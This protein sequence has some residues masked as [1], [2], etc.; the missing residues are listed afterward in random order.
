MTFLIL[1]SSASFAKKL[2]GDIVVFDN[3]EEAASYLLP[4]LWSYVP[5]VAYKEDYRVVEGIINDLWP[6]FCKEYPDCENYP[7]PE[8]VFSYT[9]GSTAF[10]MLF[11]GEMRQTNAIRISFELMDNPKN[12]EF[13]LAHEMFHYFEKHALTHDLKEEISEINRQVYG[14]CMEYTYPLDEVKDDLL[15]LMG[16]IEEIGEKPHMVSTWN[17]LPL[18]GEMGVL[19]RDMILKVQYFGEECRQLY[20]LFSSL[21]TR[22]SE[23]N[24]LYPNDPQV[25]EFLTI[26]S[27][28]F[29][30]YDG[31]L[32]KDSMTGALTSLQVSNPN[33]WGDLQKIIDE[34]GPE[35][36]RL[37]S[38]RNKKYQDYLYLSR[39][40][41]AP[42]LRFITEED[43]AD[44]RAIRLLLEK[45]VTNIES[46]VDYLLVEL[47]SKDQIRCKD[48]LSKGREPNYG[49][50]T[51]PHH[52]ECW[53]IWRA[54]RMEEQFNKEKESK[55]NREIPT[56]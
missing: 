24:Y 18:D 8:V 32:L 52:S 44:I 41:S 5:E 31:N 39:K 3:K 29:E 16:L 14:N 42:Q 11:E 2:Q 21:K 35:L 54:L 25:K 46:Y 37:T 28:C 26:A 12:L 6:S 43:E 38:I 45:G 20:S 53:R 34:D 23:G 19:L 7:K 30:K 4:S 9:P 49:P 51:R 40:L 17:G 47:N 13:V 22:V 36:G 15:S 48:D 27:M 10:G 55:N 1:F 33:V 50:L 56:N